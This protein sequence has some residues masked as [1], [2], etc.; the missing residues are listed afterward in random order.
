[1]TQ[2]PDKTPPPIDAPAALNVLRPRRSYLG[3]VGLK[4]LGAWGARLGIV[5]VG[6]VGLLAVFAPILANTHPVLMK[7]TDAAPGGA[8]LTSP[9]YR[10]FTAMDVVLLVGFFLALALVLFRRGPK[11]KVWVWLGVVCATYIAASIF[12]AVRELHALSAA[13]SGAAD[14]YSTILE[15]ADAADADVKA[16]LTAYKSAIGDVWKFWITHILLYAVLLGGWVLSV[17]NLKRVQLWLLTLFGLTLVIGGVLSIPMMRISPPETTSYAK[18]RTMQA[19]GQIDW[20][21]YA[22]IPYSPGD[23]LADLPIDQRFATPGYHPTEEEIARDMRTKALTRFDLFDDQVQ[24]GTTIE[25]AYATVAGYRAEY[26]AKPSASPP[27]VR[28]AMDEIDALAQTPQR[29]RLFLM[30]TTAE[31]QDL[32]SRMIHAARIALAIG[33]V[34]TGIAVTIGVFVG[35]LMGYFSGWVDLIGMRLVEVFSAIPVIFLL[36]AIVAFWGRDLVLMMTVLGL[37]GWVGYALF[38]RAEFLK[39]RKMDYVMAARASGTGLFPLLFKHMLPNGVT[40]VLVSASFGIA[41]MILTE[42]TLSFIGLGLENEPSWGQMLSNAQ[43]VGG[44]FYWWLA[45]Y[46]IIAIFL[47]V[48]AYNM[49]GEA[50]RDALDPRAHKTTD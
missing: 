5:W 9:M 6:L 21:L 39:L 27:V 7:T 1:M 26:E 25:D 41:G 16:K 14:M 38:T 23:T 31:G 22:L 35:G 3:T 30:G 15:N 10:A 43:G 47:T 45:M 50:M 24:T 44:K 8:T 12:A 13:L 46:P 4:L 42:A 28:K 48:F 49:V 20:A 40:P 37:T 29:T 19:E 2:T 17:Y 34:A 32:A 36:I 18:Y 11:G 33:F